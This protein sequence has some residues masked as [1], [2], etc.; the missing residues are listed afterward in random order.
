MHFNNIRI[1]ETFQS[2]IKYSIFNALTLQLWIYMS[3]QT[4]LKD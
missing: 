2:T 4:L 3:Y 1:W